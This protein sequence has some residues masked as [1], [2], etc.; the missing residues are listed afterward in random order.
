MYSFISR[1]S[2]LDWVLRKG[3]R[4]Q[5]MKLRSGF[6]SHKV[7]ISL[8]CSPCN[9]GKARVYMYRTTT[10][11]VWLRLRAVSFF[12]LRTVKQSAQ[13]ARTS[14]TEF[15]LE[16][17]LYLKRK[18]TICLREIESILKTYVDN[19]TLVACFHDFITRK[20]R[21]VGSSHWQHT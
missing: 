3:V 1:C 17:R 15:M 16:N 2:T 9:G 12:S 13:D 10:Q 20:S 5:K 8:A 4:V 18:Q 19:C 11:G 14:P 6:L 7:I 21:L